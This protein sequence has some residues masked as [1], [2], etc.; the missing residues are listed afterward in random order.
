MEK[1]QKR[2]VII[3]IYIVIF[4]IIIGGVYLAVRPKSKALVCP[5]GTVEQNG[6]CLE[7]MTAQPLAAG[8]AGIVP[9][10][11]AGQYDF[12]GLVNNPNNLLGSNN[13]QYKVIFKDATGNILAER[14]GTGFILPGDSKYIIETDMA[15]QQQPQFVQLVLGQTEWTQFSNYQKPDIEVV[16]KNFDD[17]SSGV[18]YM[19]ATGLVKNQSPFDFNSIVVRIILRDDSGK[20]VALN[21]TQLNTVKSGQQRD[22]R[23]YWPNQFPGTVQDMDTQIDVNPLSSDAFVKQYFAPKQFQQRTP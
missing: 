1:D 19:E 18:G 22:F 13:F 21:S 12:Y 2:A 10:G 7:M 3:T 5:S 17:I 9:S 8:E 14:D 11:V 6:T 23:V 16:N 20:I 15:S 4:L